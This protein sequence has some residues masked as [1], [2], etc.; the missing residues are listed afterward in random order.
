ML[1]AYGG[2]TATRWNVLITDPTNLMEGKIMAQKDSMIRYS[3]ADDYIEVEEFANAKRY[4]NYDAM[5]EVNEK[6]LSNKTGFVFYRQ[7]PSKILE[8]KV[9]YQ[10]ERRLEEVLVKQFTSLSLL[11]FKKIK[12]PLNL[13]FRNV[14]DPHDESQ[15]KRAWVGLF[16]GLIIFIFIA[17]F[18]MSLLRS[19]SREKSNRIVEVLLGSVRPMQL[20]FGKILGIGMAA[21][22]QFSIW[23]VTITIG[24]LVMRTTLFPDYLRSNLNQSVQIDAQVR[25]TNDIELAFNSFEYNEFVDLVFDRVQFTPMVIAFI[26]CL[27]GGY[28]FYSSL[29]SAVGASVGS[30]SDGQQFVI[31][32]ILLLCFGVYAGYF[33]MENPEAPLTAWLYYLPFTAPSVVMVKLSQGF[34]PGQ[35]YSLIL[36]GLILLV[37]SLFMLWISGRVYKN[38]ILKF[39]H[40]LKLGHFFKWTKNN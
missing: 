26:L 7:L 1:F 19:T 33:A 10:V 3:F 4:Q 11:D 24:L 32:L 18:A 15:D 39:G 28:L 20:M 9:Q 2:K 40:R 34:L 23:L 35:A 25:A 36:V 5:V 31:P 22:F 21:L 13:S 29:F 27:I 12:Q 8:K 6:V 14:Y 16:F 30:E 17:L 38:G 37:S